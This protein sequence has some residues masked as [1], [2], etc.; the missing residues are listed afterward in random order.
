[1][2]MRR[3]SLLVAAVALVAITHPRA[4]TPTE[5]VESFRTSTSD[6]VV[7]PVSVMDRHRQFVA[8]LPAERFTVLDNGR[9]QPITFF[10]NEDTPVSLA[11]V[12]DGSG[13]MRAKL[14]EVMAASLTL[15][16][17]SN[18]ADEVVV[19]AFND[20][21]RDALEGRRIAASDVPEL[22]K[23]LRTM[24]P[25]GR[26]ALYDGVLDGLDHL[27]TSRLPRKVIVLVSD[28][29]DNASRATLDQVLARARESNVTI[30]T[31]GVF[32]RDD[33]DRNERIL[34]HLADTTGGE[35]FTPESPGLVVSACF[36][37]ARAI[38]SG[39][40]IAFVPPE[41]DGTF[42]RVRVQIDGP[43]G[44]RLD[45]RTREGYYAGSGAE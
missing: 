21:V 35:H 24:T 31:I 32:D 41:R 44:R 23:A 14:G 28:G 29:G 26:T 1:M 9:R 19:I 8:D 36:R 5:E 2:S 22:E 10:S 34:K 38:R 6:L 37:I 42:H 39:Y 7:L 25:A 20:E 13:S 43:D 18:P 4:Q 16:K 12:I 30:Y 45:V 15:A 17:S 3:L 33:P 40:T 11:L 27:A